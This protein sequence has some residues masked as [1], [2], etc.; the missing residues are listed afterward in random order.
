MLRR[1]I[2]S[3]ALAAVTL[4]TAV[5]PAR[6]ATRDRIPVVAAF[7]PVAWAAER[8]GGTRVAVENLTPPGAEPHDLELSTDQRDAVEDAAVVFVLGRGF[9]PAVEAA[10]ERRDGPTVSLLDRR[11]IGGGAS[12]DPHVWLDPSRM[13]AIVDAVRRGLSD[14]GPEDRAR[15]RR[16]AAD[17][18]KELEALDE[19]FRE[20]LA[21]CRLDTFVTSHEA[22]GHLADAYGLRQEGVAGISPDAEPDA[23]RLGELADLVREHGITTVFTE[24]L[25]SPRIAETL[26]RE[27]GGVRTEVLNPLEGLSPAERRAGDDYVSV[28]DANLAKLRAALDCA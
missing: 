3:S 5:T 24:E 7:Y 6:A 10:A 1:T 25:V 22:F 8:V 13:I 23:R 27:A 18:V 17:T 28:M 21:E 9:Q 16:R 20:G 2:V 14:A 26:A 4:A 15:F 19:R 11:A 12:S